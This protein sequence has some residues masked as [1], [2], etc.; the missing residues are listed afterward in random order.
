MAEKRKKVSEL[1]K[2]A[3]IPSKEFLQILKK[4]K[5]AAGGASSTISEEEARKAME[6]L[7]K[8]GGRQAKKPSAE[9]PAG[10]EEKALPKKRP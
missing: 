3:G 2:E 5:I 6:L 4:M 7:K 1:A 10:K 8:V 9:I